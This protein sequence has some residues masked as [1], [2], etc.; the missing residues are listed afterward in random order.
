MVLKENAQPNTQEK[1]T[2][3]KP[4]QKHLRRP[5]QMPL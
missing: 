4:E 1:K 5:S 3:D 2:E